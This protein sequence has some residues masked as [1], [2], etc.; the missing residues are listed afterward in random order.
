MIIYLQNIKKTISIPDIIPIKNNIYYIL[1]YY[2]NYPIDSFYL[3]NKN[4][5]KIIDIRENINLL[6]YRNDNLL[7]LDIQFRDRGGFI[8]DLIS[9]FF[10][11]I[12]YPIVYP[13]KGILQAFLMLIKAIMYMFALL[14]YFIKVMAWFFGD[15]L[16]SLP[17]DFILTIKQL[18]GAII[19]AVV[20]TGMHYI[21]KAVNS[22][23]YMTVKATLGWDNTPSENTPND[24]ESDYFNNSCADKK[25]Y[26]TPDG[27][28][29]FSVVIATIL[30]PPVG[31]FMEYGILGWFNILIAALLTLMFYFPGLIYALILLYC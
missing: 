22:L 18:A 25:C 26:K 1:S 19:E 21:K 11:I 3:I 28:V 7:I 31:V 8:L 15:F 4:N 23:G 5:N 24:S 16:P 13:F 17:A 20:G 12:L 27:T 14:L 9:K 29:P 30:C 10:E 2:L 6:N